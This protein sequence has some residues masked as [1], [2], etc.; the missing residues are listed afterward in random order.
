MILLKIK[1]RN[2]RV[3]KHLKKLRNIVDLLSDIKKIFR[4]RKLNYLKEKQQGGSNYGPY[5]PNKEIIS[6]Q[7]KSTC[8]NSLDK[9]PV[10]AWPNRYVC[11]S[12]CQNWA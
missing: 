8:F 12:G 3:K 4:F 11:G 1:F 2:F 7:T 9:T 5:A 6:D 10:T